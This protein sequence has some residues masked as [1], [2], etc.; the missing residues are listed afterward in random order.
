MTIHDASNLLRRHLLTAAGALMVPAA[1]A[2]DTLDEAE[3]WD[4][5][6]SDHFLK[7]QKVQRDID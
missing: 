6:W 3:K 7:G 5:Q 4:K 1:M 2:Q